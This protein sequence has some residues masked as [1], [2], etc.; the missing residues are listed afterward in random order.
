MARWPV[1]VGGGLSVFRLIYDAFPGKD[2]LNS[3]LE[4]WPGPYCRS[5]SWAAK[6]FT[7]AG[8]GGTVCKLRLCLWPCCLVALA[9]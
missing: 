8:R 6:H 9:F 5:I 1:A 4:V 3:A 2:G 7:G